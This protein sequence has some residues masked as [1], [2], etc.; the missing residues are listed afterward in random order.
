[1]QILINIIACIAAFGFMEAFAWF[2]HKYIMHGVGWFLHKSHHEP[3]H[4][5]FELNDLYAIIFAAPAIY[6]MWIGSPEYNWLFWTGTGISLYGLCYFGFHD[7]IVH[8]RLKHGY[9]PH[10]RYMQRIVR[11]HKMHH[12]KMERTNGEA[13]GFL[14][15]L[16]KYDV[17]KT[18]DQ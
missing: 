13:F 5:R 2:M 7:V 18:D 9:K 4:G 6:L 11:A 10:S 3:R 17:K 14:F 1:M 15:A 16:P 12:K 8:R